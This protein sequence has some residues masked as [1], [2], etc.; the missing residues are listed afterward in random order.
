[1]DTTTF[2]ATELEHF[3]REHTNI[4]TCRAY[5]ANPTLGNARALTNIIAAVLRGAS[6]RVAVVEPEVA[7]EPIVATPEPESDE[8]KA[9]KDNG[10]PWSGRYTIETAQGHRTFRVRTQDSDDEFM[11]GKTLIAYLSGS[12][13]HS[14]YTNFGTLVD[15]RA[16]IWKKHQ[17]NAQLVADVAQ[18]L[19]DVDAA[20][21][22]VECKRCH[23]D[24]TV[25]QSIRQG[26][27]PTCI[28]KGD[29]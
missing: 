26:Y 14:D 5:L 8:P 16:R 27:G 22:T 17:G 11:P 1:M 13:N 3:A 29:R 6:K 10:N 12:D 19:G 7:P 21:V 2:P 24:L 23:D 18:F 15:G 28:T 9:P 4:T 25:P 20:L